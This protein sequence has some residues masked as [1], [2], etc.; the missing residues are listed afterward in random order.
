MLQ[1]LFSLNYKT[2]KGKFINL[3]EKRNCFV[4]RKTGSRPPI[5]K[6]DFV[7]VDKEEEKEDWKKTGVFEPF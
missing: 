7:L 3:L 5:L 4:N 1:A 2:S 6:E